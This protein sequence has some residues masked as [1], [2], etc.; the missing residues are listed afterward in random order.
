MPR[1]CSQNTWDPARNHCSAP[2]QSAAD[3]EPAVPV[4]DFKPR[5]Q[6]KHGPVEL[7]T[8]ASA[9]SA[10]SVGGLSARGSTTTSASQADAKWVQCE[11]PRCGK[12]RIVPP[13]ID[14][15]SL[16]PKWFCHMNTWDR[17][18]ADCSVPEDQWEPATSSSGRGRRGPL[19]KS[20]SAANLT[21]TVQGIAAPGITAAPSAPTVTAKPGKK[22]P[23]NWVS[24]ESCGKWR[25]VPHHINLDALQKQKWYCS[26]NT[27]DSRWGCTFDVQFAR[28]DTR[29][30][31]GLHHVLLLR[32]QRISLHPSQTHPSRLLG[33][34]AQPP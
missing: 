6:A 28:C 31:A 19:P 33:C 17:T 13:Q 16:P 24:C 1:Y 2:E 15:K 11:A 30:G 18:K 21:G 14:V 34:L 20:Y 3:A 12:W 32:N 25:V 7:I 8:P 29:A 10:G 27:W 4:G 9:V 26:M 5:K 22:A 23:V